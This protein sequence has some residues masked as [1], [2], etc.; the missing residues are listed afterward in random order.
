[1]PDV[2]IFTPLNVGLLVIELAIVVAVVWAF[3]D[4]ATRP[5]AAFVAAGKLTKPTWLLILGVSAVCVLLSILA[6]VAL[7]ASIVYFVDVRPRVREYGQGPRT[8]P[9]GPW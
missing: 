5:A 4:A 7:I 1:L 2:S 8:G 3:I 6:L 9:Y